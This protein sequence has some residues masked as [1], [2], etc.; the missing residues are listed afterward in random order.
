MGEDEGEVESGGEGAGYAVG[1]LVLGVVGGGVGCLGARGD[2]VEM[3]RFVGLV[4]GSEADL[5]RIGLQLEY[6]DQ[7]SRIEA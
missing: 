3:L 7:R 5:E 2:G 6:V 4:V 1:G